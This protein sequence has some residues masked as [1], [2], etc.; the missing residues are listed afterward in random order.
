[1]IHLIVLGKLN[2]FTSPEYIFNLGVIE[3]AT[4]VKEIGINGSTYS[5]LKVEN[6]EEISFFLDIGKFIPGRCVPEF[7]F[8]YVDK[9]ISNETLWSPSIFWMFDGKSCEREIIRFSRMT[10]RQAVFYYGESQVSIIHSL[11]TKFAREE[12]VSP[13]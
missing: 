2:A 4:F 11:D 8:D 12:L 10:I 5:V 9:T 7:T 6:T 1:M 13:N 3:D